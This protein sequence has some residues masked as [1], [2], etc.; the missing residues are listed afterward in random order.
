MYIGCNLE[1]SSC[2]LRLNL[3]EK[4]NLN[5]H[6]ELAEQPNGLKVELKQHQLTMLAAMQNLENNRT[7]VY[8]HT[9]MYSSIGVCGDK[10]GAGKSI[11]ILSLIASRPAY[12]LGERITG[13]F[14]A[15]VYL[16]NTFVN[17]YVKSN[18][19]VAPHSCIPQW[20]RYITEFTN[21]PFLCIAKRIDIDKFDVDSCVNQ[22]GIVLC[23]S[24]MYNEFMY[25]QRVVWSRVIFDEA[26][27]INIPAAKS[28]EANFVWF[29]TSSLQNLLF[30]SGRYY[31]T[32]TKYTFGIKKVG[33]IRDT[34]KLFERS[35]AD[36]IID[37]IVL[38]NDSSYV[39]DSFQITP[40]ECT[41][42]KCR[43][44]H[45]L[46]A[47]IGNI[48]NDIIEMLNAGNVTGAIE[49][50]GCP[51]DTHEN[52]VTSVTSSLR[53]RLENTKRE[54]DYTKSL[55]YV[56]ECE[57]QQQAQKVKSLENTISNIQTRINS[58]TERVKTFDQG[59]CNICYDDH[60]KPTIVK[61]CQNVFCFECITRA[62]NTRATC[63]MCRNPLSKEDLS[64]FGKTVHNKESL[65]SKEWALQNIL[66]ENPRGKFLI[67]SSHDESFSYIENVL[68]TTNKEYT[69]LMGSMGRINSIIDKYKNG[70]LDTLMLNANHYGT[71]LNLENTTH[72]I[73]YHKMSSDMESQV[74]GRAQRSGRKTKLKIYYLYQ[75]NEIQT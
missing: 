63:P 26:D 35:E 59:V 51:V 1:G 54:L 37:K 41:I 56:R 38:K 27:S 11:E 75:E 32:V 24:S 29:V 33:Y 34:F 5:K 74:I 47:L 71:G 43:T 4:G 12:N 22:N 42:V 69:R 73:F 45:Y 28:P 55:V 46:R 60:V 70:N 30:P 6:S 2:K 10:T 61:C 50:I 57:V 16:K 13:R 62:L 19:I 68:M 21:L 15:V 64:I 40:P 20:K 65:P 31:D 48:N 52:I 44:P 53:L 8:Q 25:T 72:L 67:F 14:G 7:K 49:R 18:L 3:I 39:D 36:I 66:Q 17:D 23:S 9:S 58:I